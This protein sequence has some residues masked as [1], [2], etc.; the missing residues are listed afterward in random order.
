MANVNKVILIGR[1]TDDAPTK[2][3]PNG[4]A[5]LNFSLAVNEQWRDKTTGEKKEKVE[6]VRVTAYGKQAEVLA[7]Y[8]DKGST[9]Y[10]EG[11]MQTRKWE[12]DGVTRYTTEVIVNEFQFL[13]KKPQGQAPARPAEAATSTATAG[14]EDGFDDETIPF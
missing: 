13:D 5:V 9:L 6:F 10:I 11:K 8:T 14:D 1:R 4:N 3:M 12:K 2:F 7:E